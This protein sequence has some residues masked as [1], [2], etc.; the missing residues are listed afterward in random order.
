MTFVAAVFVVCLIIGA[1]FSG[2]PTPW[3]AYVEVPILSILLLSFG[4]WFD[5]KT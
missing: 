4:A 1:F 3:S 2:G 5:G